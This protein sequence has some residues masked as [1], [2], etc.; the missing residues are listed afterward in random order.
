MNR[1]NQGRPIFRLIPKPA[2]VMTTAMTALAWSANLAQAKD[3][4]FDWHRWCAFA[5]DPAA[6]EVAS[7]YIGAGVLAVLA[8]GI[9]RRM[10]ARRK[11]ASSN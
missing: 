9:I 5:G 11:A 4:D 1:L 8:V 7:W 2:M 3:H 10:A 6:P